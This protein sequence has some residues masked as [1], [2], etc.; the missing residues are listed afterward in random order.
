MQI[1]RTDSHNFD[2]IALVKELDKHLS[3]KNGESDAFFRQYNKIDLIKN[4]VVSYIDNVAVGIGAFKYFDPTT[5]E[6]KRMYVSPLKRGKGLATKILA[7]LEAW[8]VELG[9]ENAV[10]ETGTTMDD[11]ISLYLKNEYEVSVNYGQYIGV[12]NSICFKKRLK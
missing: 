9:Y 11:A 7:E 2:F 5:V 12:D 4:V 8:A 1:V 6:I 10:L 3:V